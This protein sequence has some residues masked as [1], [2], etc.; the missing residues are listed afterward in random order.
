MKTSWKAIGTLGL[1]FGAIAPGLAQSIGQMDTFEDGTTQGWTS[2]LLGAQNPNPPV[3]VA[4]GGPSGVDDNY[5]LL[6]SNGTFGPGGR[7]VGIN[8]DQWSGDYTAAGITG[9][10][11]DVKNFGTTDLNLRLLFESV[12]Q[13]GPTDIATTTDGVFLAAGSDWTHIHFDISSSDL[14]ALMGT[15]DNALGNAS[16]FRVFNSSAAQ[17]PGPSTISSLG[18]D[19]VEAVPE[20][21]TMAALLGG[22]AFFAKRRKR[23]S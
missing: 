6:T 3:N 2:A 4:T 5:L 9:I 17:F 21:A 19:N 7:L 10:D 8:V 20:P 1:C 11:M 16:A 15:S 22:L 12:G 18:V 14:T 23:Q 13:S